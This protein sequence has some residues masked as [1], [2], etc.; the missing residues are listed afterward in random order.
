[1]ARIP[2]G[3]LGGLRGRIGNIIGASWKGINYIRSMP[4]SVA[5]P[6]TVLQQAQRGAFTQCVAAA[7]LL[8]ADIIATYWDPFA[9][10]MSG[11]NHF[12]SVCID[13]FATAGLTTPSS[14]S[15]ARGILTGVV[16]FV[17]TGGEGAGAFSFADTDQS[18]IGDAL[19]DDKAVMVWY[20][21][22]QDYWKTKVAEV[23]DRTDT[24]F[25]VADTDLLENDVVEAYMF[26][27]R[28]DHSKQSDSAHDQVTV[29]V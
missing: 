6:N 15:A 25:A 4:L 27:T 29:G 20:N 14:F 21:V 18:G 28:P 8:L 9:R 26:Y 10:A 3:I 5:N 17:A 7:R 23:N 2:Q 13:A 1:M 16:D 12:I 24:P 11:Y 22:T 19:G